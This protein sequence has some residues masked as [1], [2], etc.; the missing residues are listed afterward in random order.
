MVAYYDQS[1]H[2]TISGDEAR[3]GVTGHNV[4]YV[5]V[6]ST[7]GVIAAF[8]AIATYF[9]FDHL[10][11]ALSAAFARDPAEVLRSLA[12]YAAIVSLA[13]VVGVLLLGLWHL[14]AGRSG[15]ASESFMRARVVTQFAVICVI[16]AILYVA[17]YGV[18]QL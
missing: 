18:P 5:L 10:R 6:L 1:H 14:V 8:A 11:Q 12:P 7:A 4:R 15:D 9:G 16:M 3:G 17:T 2:L 13:A